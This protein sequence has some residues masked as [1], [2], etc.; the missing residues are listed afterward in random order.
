MQYLP[1]LA[2]T[3]GHKDERGSGWLHT[4][5]LVVSDERSQLHQS[6][7]STEIIYL[8]IHLNSKKKLHL[9]SQHSAMPF[10]ALNF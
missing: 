4:K 3:I 2:W 1:S 6:Q 8:I 7:T 5:W 10:I 9:S